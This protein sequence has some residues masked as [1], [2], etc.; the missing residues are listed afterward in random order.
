MQTQIPN[1]PFYTCRRDE[2]DGELLSA[3]AHISPSNCVTVKP[4][5]NSI[6]QEKYGSGQ[7]TTSEFDYY[8]KGEAI[9]IHRVEYDKY[10]EQTLKNI[11]N[12]LEP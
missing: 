6:D 12:L 4:N 5:R 10:F 8:V 3:T 9:L 1:F 11:V 7:V 2:D